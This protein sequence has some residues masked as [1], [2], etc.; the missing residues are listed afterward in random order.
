M[1]M[2]TQNGRWMAEFFIHEGKLIESYP[3]YLISSVMPF[4]EPSVH[5]ILEAPAG[6]VSA[7][8]F[9]DE[10]RLLAGR[11]AVMAID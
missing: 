2:R 3:A 9:H 8:F 11:I 5:L 10:V 7:A 4:S 6:A 1:S